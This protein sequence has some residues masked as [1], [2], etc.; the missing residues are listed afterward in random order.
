MSEAPAP[1]LAHRLEYHAFRAVERLLGRVR[2]SDCVAFGRAMG[3]LFHALSPRYRRLV[4]R[5]LRIATADTPP[6]PGRLDALVRET[7]RR[8]GA[9]FVAALRTPSLD[10]DEL[11]QIGI[12]DG[13][14]L[15]G[16]RGPGRPGLVVAMPHMGNW[17]ALTRLG[18]GYVGEGADYGG[19]YRPLDNP[20]MDALTR[21]RRSADGARLFSR[22]DGFHPPARMLRE[23]GVLGVLADQRAGGRGTALPFFGKLTSCSPL[24]ELLARRGRAE[25]GIVA[26]VSETRGR[27]RMIARPEPTCDA[28][29]H[30]TASVMQGIES[31]MRRSLPDVLWFHDRWRTDNKRPLSLFTG[32]DPSMAAAATVPLRLLLTLPAAAEPG[33]AIR[34]FIDRLFEKRPDLR[35]DLLGPCPIEDIRLHAHYWD[36]DQPPEHADAVLRRIDATHAAPLDGALLLGSESALAHA[37]KR[38][39]LRP[40]IGLGVSGK[41]WT[42]SFTPPASAE[43]WIEIAEE[44]AWVPPR[45]RR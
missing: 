14:S 11:H 10:P 28:G 24:P 16:G 18:K 41:P 27:W 35:I 13:M 42:R 6:P 3:L 1:T 40:V 2:M 5:N 19:V 17:E 36:P 7:F 38:L 37:S 43:D 20:L 44:L 26:I 25:I 12:D 33:G 30:S 29:K 39:G 21:E 22:K 15:L 34:G 31:A 32:I 4:R 8:A 23:G 9:N 45:N